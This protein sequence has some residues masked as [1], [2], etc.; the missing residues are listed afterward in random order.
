MRPCLKAFF[1]PLLFS[2]LTTEGVLAEITVVKGTGTDAVSPEVAATPAY[3]EWARKHAEWQRNYNLWEK[4][5]QKWLEEQSRL[6]DGLMVSLGGGLSPSRVNTVLS[7]GNNIDFPDAPPYP[8]INLRGLGGVIDLRAGWLVKND[9]YLAGYYFGKDELHDQMYLSLDF[10]ARWTP[11]TQLRFNQS[12]TDNVG[13]F[14]HAAYSLD[15][16]AGIGTTYILYPYLISFSSTVGLGLVAIQK[17]NSTD[18]DAK[19][20]RTDLG[21]ALNFRV[22][23]EWRVSE[24]WKSGFSLNYGYM[25]AINRPRV[26]ERNNTYQE[27]YHSHLFSIQWINTFTPPKYLRGAPPKKPQ[28]WQPFAAPQK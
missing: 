19:N 9:P 24:N 14:A 18:F 25:Q 27:F 20:I 7:G 6:D 3:K 21:P 10:L 16:I 26:E 5:Y 17:I 22:G 13:G 28:Q 8:E 2:V 11:Y 15:L 12:D 23:Q 4:G 1:L